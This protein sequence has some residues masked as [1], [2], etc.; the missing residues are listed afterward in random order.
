MALAPAIAAAGDALPLAA[1]R[2]GQ[3]MIDAAAVAE[4]LAEVAIQAPDL[5]DEPSG[6]S[7]DHF[8]HR[9]AYTT[10]LTANLLG[11]ADD[12]AGA[13]FPPPR[14]HMP[15]AWPRLV[16]SLG[17]RLE[18]ARRQAPRGELSWRPRIQPGF[19]SRH[20]PQWSE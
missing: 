15:S 5:L 10:H 19:R 2:G 12:G 11:E 7:L 1:N 18:R 13:I 3:R 17:V 9:L 20:V 4:S 8:A 14:M 16:E 6:T